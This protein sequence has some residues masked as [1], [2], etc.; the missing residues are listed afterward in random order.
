DLYKSAEFYIKYLGFK[1]EVTE[2]EPPSWMQLRNGDTIIMLVTYDYAKKDIPNFKD[3]TLS[4]NL[5]KFR[6][7]SLDEVKEIYENMKRDNKNIFLDFRKSDY[8][9]EFGVFD[10]DD[11]MILVTKVTD[12]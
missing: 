7:P 5:Y 4:T 12:E 3:Y 2:Y 8:R 6:Y 9:Y 11:N 1:E 10:E